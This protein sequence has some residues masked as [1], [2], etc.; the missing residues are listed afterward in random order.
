MTIRYENKEYVLEKSLLE[1]DESTSTPNELANHKQHY[2]EA[3]KVSCIIVAT[4]VHEMQKSYE[5]Y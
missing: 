1:I 2:H 4:M 5:D 3:P